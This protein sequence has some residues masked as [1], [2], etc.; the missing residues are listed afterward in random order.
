MDTIRVYH[1]IWKSGLLVA[2]CLGFTASGIFL[3]NAGE[4]SI[5]I[6]LGILFF[7]I[8]GLFMLWFILK[9][10]ITNTPYYLITDDGI[11]M[12]SPFRS[13]EVHFADVECFFL[14]KVKTS[15]GIN[16]KFIG[17]QY[18]EN[19]ESQQFKDASMAG[20]AVRSANM[21]MVGSQEA[22]PAEGLTI[23]PKDLCE[24]LNERVNSNLSN[25]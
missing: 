14:T 2:V 17:I 10:R 1:S 6:W 9:E 12:N 22:L 7:G 21:S 4:D 5:I 15:R 13:F 3:I 11:I 20:R 24:I 23:K 19:V 18:K 16:T 25:N 8:G